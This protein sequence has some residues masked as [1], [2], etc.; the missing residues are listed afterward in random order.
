MMALVSP[1]E[2]LG[3]SDLIVVGTVLA[4]TRL[5]DTPASFAGQ[6]T[7]RVDRVLKGTAIGKIT[8]R[9]AAIPVL[10]P[11]MIIM[12]HGGFSL[13]PQQQYLFYLTRTQGGYTLV[14]GLQGRRPATDADTVAQA[15]KEI[16][17]TVTLNGPIGPC[18]FGKPV[19]I[20][21][22]VTNRGAL[23]VRIYDRALEGFY[24]TTH[25]GTQVEFRTVPNPSAAAPS[26]ETAQPILEPAKSKTFSVSLA[27]V[28]PESWK[29][30]DADS[31]FLTPA[32]VRAR[33]FILPVKPNNPTS[34]MGGYNIASNWVNTL[35]GSPPPEE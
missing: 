18:Y 19:Q 15:L 10:P 8:V 25:V 35:I 5:P 9:H 23:P 12:D 20:T 24:Y 27:V 31:Y 28:Q 16:P 1:Q 14:G 2:L 4:D 34:N 29:K 26:G 6:A 17:V 3:T 21:L 33:V 30:S 32:A 7:V 11:G 13:A 22:M